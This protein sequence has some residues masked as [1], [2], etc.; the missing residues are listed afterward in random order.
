MERTEYDQKVNEMTSEGIPIGEAHY[1]V[2]KSE[3]E[4]AN[5]KYHNISGLWPNDDASSKAAFNG[6]VK[7][8][9]IKIPKGSKIILFRT[10]SDNE[11]A[12]AYNLVWTRS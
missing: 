7:D 10:E 6:F 3:I 9:D 4:E 12:P 2:A 5:K 1:L 8:S 11:K